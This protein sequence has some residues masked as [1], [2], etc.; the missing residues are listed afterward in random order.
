MTTHLCACRSLKGG[1]G[2]RAAIAVTTAGIIHLMTLM[3]VRA[4]LMASVFL[5]PAQLSAEPRHGLSAFGELKYPADFKHFD[6]VNPAAPKGGRLSLIGPGGVITFDTFNAFILKGDAAEGLPLIHDTLM[7]PATDEPDSMYS[8]IAKTADVAADRLSVTFKL[9]PEAKFNEGTPVTSADV[10]FSFTTLKEKGHPTYRIQLRDVVSVEA[11]DALT[12]RY[13]FKGNQTRGLPGVVA[14]LP[15][16]SKAYYATRNFE[17][18]SLERPVSSGPYKI[19]EFKQGTNVTYV[20]REDYW[21]QD[22]PVNKGRYNFGEVRFEYFRDR[23]AALESFKS[24]T[25]EMRE[26]FTAKDWSTAYDIPQVKDGR[27]Q[28]LTLPDERAAA[29]QGFFLNLRKPKYADPGVRQ[30][31]DLAFDFEWSNKNLFYGLY[32]RTAS[33][34]EN[35][36]L[37]A[38]GPPSPA[39]LAP[40][41]AQ[42]PAEAFGTPYVPPVSDGSGADRKLLRQAAELLTAAGWEMKNGVRTNK[43]GAILDAE[44][45][46]NEPSFERILGPYIKNLTA[47]GI[48]ATIRRV[49]PAQYERRSKSFDFDVLVKRYAMRATPGAELNDYFSSTSADIDG[50]LNL[51]GI[52]SPAVDALIAKA[53]EAK[54]RPDLVIAM[55]ALDRVLRA[56]HYWVPQWYKGAHNLPHWNKFARPAVKPKYDLGAVDTWWVDADKQAKLKMN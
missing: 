8:L 16:L 25:I 41:K 34:F 32:K 56:G 54:T 30:A 19:G 36:E 37:K 29:A 27:I 40:F 3:T 5:L 35:S 26:E 17:E 7:A 11:P 13:A 47:I 44:F 9:R 10:A 52:K 23:T 38:S 45:L 43:D 21:A 31:F 46:L 28:L 14:G 18:T 22:L 42:L 48:Q 20:R 15:V 50:S 55:R 53:G 4:A 49:D 2:E 12:V 1:G 51:A 33:Y 6:Y 24:G 39:E